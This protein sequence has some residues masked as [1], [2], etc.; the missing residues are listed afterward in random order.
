MKPW[1]IEV[2]S[3]PA[4]SME[5]DVD[6]IVKPALIKD[7]IALNEFEPYTQFLERSKKPM[8]KNSYIKAGL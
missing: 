7:V 2:N 6:S 5:T 1:L 3:G 4:M 8:K